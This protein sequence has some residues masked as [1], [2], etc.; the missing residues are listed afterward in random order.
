MFHPAIR[1]GQRDI[2]KFGITDIKQSAHTW[3]LSLTLESLN[4]RILG[5]PLRLYLM[6]L[7]PF[8]KV[9][10]ALRILNMEH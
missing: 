6:S 1:K 8:F 10:R 7:V 5:F 9:I 3:G 4:A 2:I